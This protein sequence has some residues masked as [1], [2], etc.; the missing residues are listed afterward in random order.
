MYSVCVFVMVC[1]PTLQHAFGPPPRSVGPHMC[2]PH[3]PHPLLEEMATGVAQ[4]EPYRD[5]QGTV[6]TGDWN[7][8][9]N[10]GCGCGVL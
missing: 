9:D 2:T 6:N 1:G 3:P 4:A 7:S 8:A 5:R 10:P